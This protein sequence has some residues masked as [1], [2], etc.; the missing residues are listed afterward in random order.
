[1]QRLPLW[2]LAPP[3]TTVVNDA[4]TCPEIMVVVNC[5]FVVTTMGGTSPTLGSSTMAVTSVLKVASCFFM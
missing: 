3:V 4:P 5:S 1:M 2:L